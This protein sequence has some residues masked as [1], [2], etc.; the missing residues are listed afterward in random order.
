MMRGWL[1][2]PGIK[3]IGWNCRA[4][5]KLFIVEMGNMTPNKVMCPAY[6][7]PADLALGQLPGWNSVSQTL[8]PLTGCSVSQ[9]FSVIL[10]FPSLSAKP[11]ALKLRCSENP[12][13]ELPE[14]CAK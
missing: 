2:I 6:S 5:S 14:P 1:E 9:S 13:A 12:Q 11:V 7:H 4:L 10:Y 8:I 3:I